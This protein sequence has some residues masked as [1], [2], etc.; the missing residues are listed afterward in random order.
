ML[1]EWLRAECG[2]CAALCCVAPAFDAVQGFGFD[3]PAHHACRH[4]RQD[5]RC[6][7]HGDL[8]AL[9]FPGCA[10]YDCHGAGQWVTEQLNGGHSWRLETDGGERMFAQFMRLRPLFE[11]AM[12]LTLAIQR[13]GHSEA[14]DRAMRS[15]LAELES[16]RDA[17]AAGHP[18]FNAMP[19]RERVFVLLRQLA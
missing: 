1:P 3:K 2:R 16:V 7:I 6:D 11:L 18:V 13:G 12:L 17:E 9:G 19:W 5:N 15:M 14:L 10:V 4:L 8:H